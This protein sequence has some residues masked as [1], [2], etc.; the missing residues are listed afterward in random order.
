MRFA[1]LVENIAIDFKGMGVIS[2][3]GLGVVVISLSQHK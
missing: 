3:V 1:S 2:V